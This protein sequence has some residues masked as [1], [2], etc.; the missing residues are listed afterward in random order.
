MARQLE[1][2]ASDR[3]TILKT[4]TKKLPDAIAVANPFHVARLAEDALDERP[5]VQQGHGPPR[6]GD[7]LSAGTDAPATRRRVGVPCWQFIASPS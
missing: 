1:V 5:S 7:P 2:V 3:F 6:P 4:A